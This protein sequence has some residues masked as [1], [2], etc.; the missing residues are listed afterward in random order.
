MQL[1][2]AVCIVKLNKIKLELRKK[3]DTNE[4]DSL[5]GAVFSGIGELASGAINYIGV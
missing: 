3:G 5:F 2:A 1:T 4:E